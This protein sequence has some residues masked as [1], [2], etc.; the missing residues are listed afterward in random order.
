MA[1]P[2]GTS[3]F[4]SRDVF[5]HDGTIDQPPSAGNGWPDVRHCNLLSK[6]GGSGCVLN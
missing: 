5:T 3:K 4:L 1:G 2:V 6:A